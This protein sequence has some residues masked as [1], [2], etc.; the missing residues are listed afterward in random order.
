MFPELRAL[1]DVVAGATPGP[2]ALREAARLTLDSVACMA[3]GAQ[4]TI[5]RAARALAAPCAGAGAS[6]AGSGRPT[7]CA[8]AAGA[9]ARM[10]A[11]LDADDTFM[12]LHFGVPT[13]AAALAVGETRRATGREV[14]EAVVVG[15]EAGARMVRAVGPIVQVAA[16]RLV[17]YRRPQPASVASVFGAVAAAARV[18]RLPARSTEH[19]FAI[20]GANM[21]LPV[22]HKWAE[23]PDGGPLPLYKYS[24]SGAC[25]AVAV[26]AALLAAEGV[27]GMLGLFEG[28]DSLW[29]LCG[30]APRLPEL[31]EGLG[32]RWHI[33]D[34]S[35]KP[36]PS[37]RWL[38]YPLTGLLELL[39]E[40]RVDADEV[41][42]I[43]VRGPLSVCGTRRRA[44]PSPDSWI[45][46]QFNLTHSV[47]ML[48][49]GVPPGVEWSAADVMRRVDV[50]GMRERVRVE[51]DDRLNHIGQHF[52]GGHL[53]RLPV[54]VDL[55]V[56]G[57]RR[58]TVAAFA[59]GDPWAP[60]TRMTDAEL[61][62]KLR[63][64]AGA[65][66]DNAAAAILALDQ[67][68]CLG[69][70]VATLRG[71]PAL[72]RTS[73]LEPLTSEVRTA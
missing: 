34:T 55:V 26:D 57:R 22:A 66:D 1:V 5:G 48:L 40:E 39:T 60:A 23:D 45:A 10:G 11:A 24:D 42:E 67:A 68:A 6:L 61:A 43:L 53:K 36:W 70:V 21:P 3:G 59:K 37:C 52:D 41:G 69:D 65:A 64:M 62:E 19:A 72:D 8:A 15:F 44:T 56:R 28:R 7:L 50:Q 49:L 29:D 14:L 73:G 71:A 35:Y 63:V 47:A 9:N 46:A 38:H 31:S 18:L 17:G 25:A 33:L 16:G 4:T 54:A 2:A 12:M 13:V 32:E 58:S 51:M 27:T 30:G 20:A